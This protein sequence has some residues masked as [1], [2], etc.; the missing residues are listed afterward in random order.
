MAAFTVGRDIVAQPQ[1]ATGM[2]RTTQGDSS[3]TI[4]SPRPT[5]TRWGLRRARIS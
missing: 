3:G 1:R 2:P 4:A 5:R